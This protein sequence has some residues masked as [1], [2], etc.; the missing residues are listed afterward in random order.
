MHAKVP[1]PFIIGETKRWRC[2]N[3]DVIVLDNTSK[4]FH[5]T[6]LAKWIVRPPPACTLYGALSVVFATFALF[7]DVRP[8]IAAGVVT[9]TAMWFTWRPDVRHP[10]R[11]REEDDAEGG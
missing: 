10:N 9:G 7:H 4:P 8:A 6:R 11:K 5:E 1:S 2:G 3:N